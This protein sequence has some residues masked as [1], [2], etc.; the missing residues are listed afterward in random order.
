[1][2]KLF[3]IAS[4]FMFNLAHGKSNQNILIN[5]KSGSQNLHA[6]FMAVKIGS[7]L[8]E[9]KQSVTIFSNMEGVR[10][11]DSR[12][13]LNLTFGQGKQSLDVIYSKFIKLG[14]KVVVCS[15]C[16]SAIG[17]TS[18]YLRKGSTLG[19]ADSVSQAIIK[20]DKVLDY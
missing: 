14:G 9:K 13:P 15:P 18:K 10:L 3:L 19:T 8:L 7:M 5:L 20:A 17:L 4:I 1:M 12:Q 2:V 16:A 6:M 11:V